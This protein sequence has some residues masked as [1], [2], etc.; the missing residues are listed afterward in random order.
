MATVSDSDCADLKKG[1]SCC[2]PENITG[3]LK[4]NEI[5]YDNTKKKYMKNPKYTQMD[6]CILPTCNGLKELIIN[7]KYNKILNII[8]C[9]STWYNRVYSLYLALKMAGVQAGRGRTGCC[10]RLRWNAS[11]KVISFNQLINLNRYRVR[12]YKTSHIEYF[13]QVVLVS[14]K[15]M[16]KAKRFISTSKEYPYQYL[17]NKNQTMYKYLNSNNKLVNQNINLNKKCECFNKSK[18]INWL[19]YRK[20]INNNYKGP[21]CDSNCS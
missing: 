10:H 4:I 5:Q 13:M 3:I 19:K 11:L 18:F 9:N 16:E 14:L 21:N 15:K 2:N 7:R 6:E 20:I 1:E 12:F 17:I 8:Q